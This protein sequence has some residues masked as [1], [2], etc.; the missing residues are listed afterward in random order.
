VNSPHHVVRV[1]RQEGK[2]AVLAPFVLSDRPSKA[3]RIDE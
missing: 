2:Q 1:G 3:A